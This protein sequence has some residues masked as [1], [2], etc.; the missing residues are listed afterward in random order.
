M[1]YFA[2]ALM[3]VCVIT[4]NYG[5]ETSDIVI[6]V[7]AAR[8]Y[9]VTDPDSSP[10]QNIPGLTLRQQGRSNTQTDLSIR[11]SSFSSSGLILNGLSLRNA[12]TEHWHGS[13]ALPL[14]W[15]S[16]GRVITGL[17]RFRLS[18]GHPAGSASLSL[19]PVYASEGNL[20]VGAGD[21]GTVFGKAEMTGVEY[22]E[23][24]TAA[25]S[26]FLNCNHTDQTDTYADN[27]LDRFSTGARLSCN[28]EKIRGDI[29]GTY[30][31][32]E[33]GAR[34]F[35]GAS[36]AYP[37]EEKLND[38]MIMGSV[39][40][41]EEPDEPASISAV[42]RQTDDIYT[43]NRYRPA[44]YR[45][46][47]ITDFFALHSDRKTILTDFLLLHARTDIEHETIRSSALGDHKRSRASAAFIP[48]WQTG[49]LTLSAGGSVELFSTD[50]DSFLPAAGAEWRFVENHSLF[51]SYTEALRQPSYT[52]LNYES[53]DSLG[54]KGLERQH[55]RTTEAGHRIETEKQFWKLALFY[56]RSTDTVDWIKES[57]KSRWNAVNLNEI[58]NFGAEVQYAAEI[59]E[60]TELS[61]ELLALLKQY[62]ADYYASRYVLDYPQFSSTITFMHK[63]TDNVIIR[64]TQSF[65]QYESNAVR[66]GG[67]RHVV[68]SASMQWIPTFCNKLVLNAGL[69]NIFDDEFQIYPGQNSLGRAIYSSLR[70]S[71]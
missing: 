51:I 43:L 55:T 33:Y 50:S 21:Y 63:L 19:A 28:S 5:A 47:H 4:E 71:W 54:N 8:I 41:I 2:T 66:K 68:S 45:K 34:G 32:S 16:Q 61:T 25:V 22:F 36:H 56:K 18:A 27:Y 38:T 30:S 6:E 40:F 31:E 67:N 57:R 70:Y 39:V 13:T 35:Y 15:L 1:R 9:P 12:Q 52:E 10:L 65:S 58:E 44:T 62:D 14:S 20:T 24:G 23:T 64:I 3:T 69:N 46:R 42:W 59:N 60:T 29:L 7:E 26:A 48:E 11:G 53:P 37:A 17:E 49:R